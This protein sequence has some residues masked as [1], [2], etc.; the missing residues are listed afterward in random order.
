MHL[1]AH[2]LCVS[3]IR[4]VNQIKDRLQADQRWEDFRDRI[5]R[6]R[7]EW[8]GQRPFEVEPTAQALVLILEEFRLREL[9][10]ASAPAPVPRVRGTTVRTRG[11]VSPSATPGARLSDF[12]EVARLLS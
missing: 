6:W 2:T 11:R 5:G 3:I 7:D 8:L 12:R 4:N 10:E 9:L 1:P